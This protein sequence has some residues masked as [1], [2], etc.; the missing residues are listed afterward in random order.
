MLLNRPLS[1]AEFVNRSNALQRKRISLMQSSTPYIS[2][3]FFCRWWYNTPHEN[4]QCN[5]LL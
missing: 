3:E 5:R 1:T 4:D 2:I